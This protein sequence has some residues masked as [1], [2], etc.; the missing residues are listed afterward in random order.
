MSGYSLVLGLA[1]AAARSVAPGA[2]A[3]AAGPP[4]TSFGRGGKVL[5]V[6]SVNKAGNAKLQGDGVI[7]V[8][9]AVKNLHVT[10]LALGVIRLRPVSQRNRRRRRALIRCS[11]KRT[12]RSFRSASLYRRTRRSPPFLRWRAI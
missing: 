5:A 4:D 7:V 11:R 12:A 9:A 6:H 10:T 2:F 8:V 3:T 1:V